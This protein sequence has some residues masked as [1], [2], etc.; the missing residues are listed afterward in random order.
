MNTLYNVDKQQILQIWPFVMCA[1]FSKILIALRGH[2]II[3]HFLFWRNISCDHFPL[4]T[5]TIMRLHSFV[6][7]FWKKQW[8]IALLIS[9]FIYSGDKKNILCESVYV[10]ARWSLS[11]SISKLKN[12]CK[13]T[14]KST[15]LLRPTF[16]INNDDHIKTNLT[17]MGMK[18]EQR[19][20]ICLLPTSNLARGILFCFIQ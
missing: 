16:R 2:C 4:S 15:F 6:C 17:W 8:I 5:K 11:P 20:L 14:R 3:F 1:E 9:F 12:M 13:N 10:R 7:C 19:F 18:H